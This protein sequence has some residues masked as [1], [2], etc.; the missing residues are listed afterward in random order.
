MVF[1]FI[2]NIAFKKP[3]YQ[4]YPYVIGNATFDAS[5][6]VD[7]RK[8]DLRWYGGQCAVSAEVNETATWWVNLTRIHSIHHIT[9]YFV[10]NNWAWGVV[11]IIYSFRDFDLS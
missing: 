6:A 5:N 9:F 3:A 4:Q 7:G 10:T 8:S 1:F 11:T 2:V